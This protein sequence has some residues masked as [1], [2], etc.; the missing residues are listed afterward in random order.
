MSFNTQIPVLEK[1][2]DL[3]LIIRRKK[4]CRITQYVVCL[5]LLDETFSGELIA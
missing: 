1:R 5:A 3:M 2:K 4:G